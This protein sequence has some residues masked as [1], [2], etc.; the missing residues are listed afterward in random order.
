MKLWGRYPHRFVSPLTLDD[1]AGWIQHVGQNTPF[2]ERHNM[3]LEGRITPHADGT[4]SFVVR[5]PKTK[6][7]VKGTLAARPDGMTD[8]AAQVYGQA[9]RLVVGLVA[10]AL[11]VAIFYSLL[12]ASLGIVVGWML[13]VLTVNQRLMTLLALQ[14]LVG[15]HPLI[16]HHYPAMFIIIGFV[17]IG[18]ATI[19]LLLA[20]AA[21]T[22]GLP[23]VAVMSI[24]ALGVIMTVRG[25]LYS[26]QLLILMALVRPASLN[27]DNDAALKRVR[28]TGFVIQR[29]FFVQM[30][31][32]R[33]NLEALVLL[34]M[35]RADEALRVLDRYQ[36]QAERRRKTDHIKE[37][38]ETRAFVLAVQA[39]DMG[40]YAAAEALA[41]QLEGSQ[42]TQVAALLLDIRLEWGANCA[43][44]WSAIRRQHANLLN[45]AYSLPE[46]DHAAAIV[47]RAWR[48]VYYATCGAPEQAYAE[49]DFLRTATPFQRPL[50]NAEVYLWQSLAYRRLNARDL[51][52]EYAQKA[53]DVLPMGRGK[54]QAERYRQ[55]AGQ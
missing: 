47:P 54:A 44:M 27:G 45:N 13:Y 24:L 52:L 23:T 55:W 3:P 31:P 5:N 4:A 30:L 34:D 48:A 39:L 15:I 22:L 21:S 41:M 18:M 38:A 35:N 37:I 1:A 2:H 14:N 42:S 19:M 33:I 53:D 11:Y 51:A 40:D 46:A 49:L 6:I 36:A 10:A 17:A 20:A 9:W 43:D 8:V 12:V 32:Q 29:I 50:K 16:T 28:R 7:A 25:V 26:A